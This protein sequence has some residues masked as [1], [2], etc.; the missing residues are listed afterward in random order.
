MRGEGERDKVKRW[1]MK[2]WMA[3]NERRVYNNL[4]QMRVEDG[5][6]F[7]EYHRVTREDFEELL[8]KVALAIEKQNTRPRIAIPPEQRLSVTLR[9][10]ATGKP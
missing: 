3:R 9:Y 5:R 6:R 1:W 4:V 2:S 8:I 7:F 10:L